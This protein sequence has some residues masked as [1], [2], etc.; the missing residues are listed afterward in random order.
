MHPLALVGNPSRVGN[1]SLISGDKNSIRLLTLFA[2]GTYAPTSG[3]L[4]TLRQR[5]TSRTG[6]ANGEMA[7]ALLSHASFAKR[8]GGS[9]NK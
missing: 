1:T 5:V 7:P 3:E 9:A 8:S 2:E 4:V 6:F